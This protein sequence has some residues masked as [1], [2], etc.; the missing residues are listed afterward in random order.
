MISG[1]WRVE[2]GKWLRRLNLCELGYGYG[3]VCMLHD[4]KGVPVTGLLWVVWVRVFFFSFFVAEICRL[5]I[6]IG[7]G[8]G[9]L[10]DGRYHFT[11]GLER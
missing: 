1:L 2:A 6:I 3:F 4:K 10:C 8:L 5:M 11:P 7:K 9:W